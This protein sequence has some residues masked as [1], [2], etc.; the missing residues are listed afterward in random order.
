MTRTWLCLLVVVGCTSGA[1]AGGDWRSGA[2]L[3]AGETRQWTQVAKH[4][5]P[6]RRALQAMAYD[7]ARRV[8]VIYGGNMLDSF[9]GDTTFQ[10]DTWEW[11]GA[12]DT[13]TDRT[14]SDGGPGPRIGAA[15]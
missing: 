14:P 10:E 15:K 12:T 2:L 9:S 6:S 11:D 8:V 13:W 3:A 4:A 1:P 5:R 7:E